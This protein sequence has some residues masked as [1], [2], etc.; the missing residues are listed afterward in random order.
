MSAPQ[1]GESPAEQPLAARHVAAAVIGNALEF[2]DFTTYV[3]FS[4]SIGHAFFPDLGQFANLMLSLGI[5]SAGFLLRPVGG[6]V[7]GTY[8]DRAGRR[9][10][11]VLSFTLAGAAIVAMALIPGY[12]T[13]GWPA[14]ILALVARG[15]QGFALG[16]EVGPAT[17]F[18]FESA[19]A[20]RRGLYASYQ[21]ASQSIAQLAGGVVGFTLA[22]VLD[23]LTFDQWGWRIAFLIGGLTVPFGYAIRR[24][25]PETLHAKES[26]AAYAPL[27]EGIS[28]L[29]THWRPIAFGV[30]VLCSGTIAT[31]SLNYL[32]TF[33]QDTL[34]M[35]VSTSLAAALVL[36]LFGVASSL[37]GGWLCDRLGRKP[38]MI[39]PRLLF[40]VLIWPLYFLIVRGRDAQALLLG[41][42]A[43]SL[44]A[45]FAAGAV[46]SA[47]S[48][49]LPRE[50]RSRSFSII[51]ST[52]I[53]IFG[54][55]TQLIETWLIRTTRSAMAPAWYLIGATAVGVIGILLIGET[56]PIRQRATGG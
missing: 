15:V 5:F 40:L 13:I 11:M 2:Y 34:H 3:I 23:P 22:H 12:A 38:V 42:A 33:A 14:P 26:F 6:V 9:P 30:M 49:G 56:A 43:L 20:R 41:T 54:G 50:I 47:L 21:S 1:G 35:V 27:V 46:Y 24:T 55:S 16:G 29:R 44:L 51:Y 25:L 8:G 4:I 39:W 53:A 32:T 48:E 7:I 31:Y 52:S 37:A 36:G 19:P 10:A 45:N 28:V 18:L 17:A